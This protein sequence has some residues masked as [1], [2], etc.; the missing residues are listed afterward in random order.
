MVAH[1]VSYLK[2]S[3]DDDEDAEP[4]VISVE[5][6]AK[7]V[8]D[9]AVEVVEAQLNDCVSDWLDKV[10]QD[11]HCPLVNERTPRQSRCQSGMSVAVSPDEDEMSRLERSA[12]ASADASSD[13]AKPIAAKPIA[14]V[15]FEKCIIDM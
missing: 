3:V 9:A 13:V 1:P 11:S 14:Q 10:F 12:A 6:R 15:V 7:T 5:G 2:T 4:V 8:V